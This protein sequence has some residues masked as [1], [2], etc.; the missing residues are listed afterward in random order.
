[1]NKQKYDTCKEATRRAR[2]LLEIIN[3]KTTY[4]SYDYLY[5][6]STVTA[7]LQ[8]QEKHNKDCLFYWDNLKEVLLK[9]KPLKERF[10]KYYSDPI[11]DEDL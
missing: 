10:E 4:F 7:H 6:A 8:F 9:L 5:D 11:L 1:M 3:G 2:E